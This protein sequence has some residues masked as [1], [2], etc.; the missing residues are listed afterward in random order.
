MDTEDRFVSFSLSLS[1][2]CSEC[3]IDDLSQSPIW[4]LPKKDEWR[5]NGLKVENRVLI[6]TLT[7]WDNQIIIKPDLYTNI[8]GYQLHVESKI[9]YKGTYL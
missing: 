6:Y 4:K 7:T 3:A 2:P 9:L 5:W 8:I 1:F